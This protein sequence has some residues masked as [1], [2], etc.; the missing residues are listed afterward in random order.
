M[1]RPIVHFE[2]IGHDPVELRSF[3]GD[4]FGWE[5]ATDQAAP[6]DVAE[7]VGDY[8]VVEP[9]MSSAGVGIPAGIGG[10]PSFE[11]RASVYVGV[12]DV[13]ATLRSVEALGGTSL[14]GP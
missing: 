1:G 12:S 7:L 8:G 6:D 14:S 3:Y 10:G 4:L 11:R 13:E 9:A 2:I 5:Y